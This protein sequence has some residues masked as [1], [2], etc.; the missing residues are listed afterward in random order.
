MQQ[1]P[2]KQRL[3][4]ASVDPRLSPEF[5]N[6]SPAVFTTPVSAAGSESGF[7]VPPPHD[8]M[9]ASRWAPGQPQAGGTSAA[10]DGLAGHLSGDPQLST[11]NAAV[12]KAG[13]N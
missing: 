7:A 8:G 13:I 10:P 5:P 11:P 6:N 12:S 4:S 1:Q 2:R 3:W 9:A